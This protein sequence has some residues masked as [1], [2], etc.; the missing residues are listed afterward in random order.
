MRKLEAPA[1]GRSKTATLPDTLASQALSRAEGP[2]Q[3][4]SLGCQTALKRLVHQLKFHIVARSRSEVPDTSMVFKHGHSDR[5]R[6]I[7]ILCQQYSWLTSGQDLEAHR[8]QAC[9]V[10]QSLHWVNWGRKTYLECGRCHPTGWA[11]GLNRER[12]SNVTK[13]SQGLGKQLRGNTPATLILQM[14][15]AEFWFQHSQKW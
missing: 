8:G 3:W 6:P 5:Q 10:R 11:P 7:D 12:A 9:V 2:L 15:G 14:W 1:P 13:L 4:W